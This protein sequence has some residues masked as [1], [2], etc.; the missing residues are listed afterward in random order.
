M[1]TPHGDETATDVK[2]LVQPKPAEPTPQ[3]EQIK[4]V[5]KPS[6]TPEAPAERAIQ[7][8]D[9]QK[10]L[11]ALSQQAQQVE[12]ALSQATGST[13]GRGQGGP[14]GGGGK[15]SGYGTGEGSGTGP[16][17]LTKTEKRRRRWQLNF[18]V[19][20]ATDH[21]NQFAAL[22]AIL[23]IPEPS[24]GFR[25]FRDLSHRHPA[26]EHVDGLEDINRLG[27]ADQ[28]PETARELSRELGM[29]A[30]PYL[31]AFF[32]KDLEEKMAA[33]EQQYYHRAE[34]EIRTKTYFQVVPK[35]LGYDI[36]INRHAYGR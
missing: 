23:A 12:Q 35:G 33:M 13:P 21:L 25:L 6:L 9:A 19:R 32:P 24:G 28:E 2:Q 34:D 22:G 11:A 31:L 16:G 29:P 36:I 1:A 4:P 26:G 17:T 3:L 5:E 14:G 10:K 27:F 7:D 15:G 20:D 18:S 8:E 30:P